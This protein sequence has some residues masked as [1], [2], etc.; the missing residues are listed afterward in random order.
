[1]SLITDKPII[2]ITKTLYFNTFRC[3]V[4][5]EEHN[6]YGTLKVIPGLPLDRSE[7]PENAPEVSPFLLILVED[8]D[9]TKD[10]LL[11]FEEKVSRAVMDRFKT[12]D[13]K[14]LHCQFFYPSPAFIFDNQ[15]DL[16]N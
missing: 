1:M 3:L 11:D 10:T 16:K 6:I 7:V 14:P 8:A 5:D 9:V 13:F 12:D 4:T 2:K 15:E